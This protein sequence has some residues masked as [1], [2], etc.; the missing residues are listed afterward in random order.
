MPYKNFPNRPVLL[1]KE[2]PYRY[3]ALLLYALVRQT[4][5]TSSFHRLVLSKSVSNYTRLS[6]TWKYYFFGFS[7][8]P[9]KRKRRDFLEKQRRRSLPLNTWRFPFQRRFI[10]I[11]LNN[12]LEIRICHRTLLK[13]TVVFLAASYLQGWLTEPNHNATSP[14]ITHYNPP[15]TTSWT[16]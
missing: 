16:A 6:N 5:L 1:E 4:Q 7:I 10:P 8:C 2:L 3:Q 15:S 13:V 11:Q 12:R 14:S 9:V